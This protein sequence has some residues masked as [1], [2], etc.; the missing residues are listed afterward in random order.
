MI[1][2]L[3]PNLK[4]APEEL[5]PPC[6]KFKHTFSGSLEPTGA[7]LRLLGHREGGMAGWLAVMFRDWK[8]TNPEL[9]HPNVLC[10]LP[11]RHAGN[12]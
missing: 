3:K 5:D 6:L 7:R 2:P 11:T 10:P 9:S 12:S 1:V 8:F 4:L